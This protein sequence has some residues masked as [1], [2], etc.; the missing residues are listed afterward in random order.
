MRLFWLAAATA[1]IALPAL[2]TP[3]DTKAADTSAAPSKPLKWD[4]L[5]VRADKA[6]PRQTV[7][8]EIPRGRDR[9]SFPPEVVAG[10]ADRGDKAP[11][12]DADPPASKR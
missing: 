11:A 12:K 10:G 1:L 5:D 7:R 4:G 9:F 3:A 8:A 6:P 2:A